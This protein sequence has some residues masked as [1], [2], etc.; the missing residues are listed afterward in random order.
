MKYGYSAK[1]RLGHQQ[2][3]GLQGKDN[4]KYNLNLVT[5]CQ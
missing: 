4:S 1:S 3:K 5:S 2:P